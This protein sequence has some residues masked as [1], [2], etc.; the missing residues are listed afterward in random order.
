MTKLLSA[1]REILVAIYLR[2]SRDDQ[3]GDAE[4][5][6]IAHQRDM[7]LAYCEERGWKV[8]DIYIDDGDIIGLNQKTF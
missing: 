6:S 1:I 8:Y 3:N 7:L 2:L 5:M 4:S